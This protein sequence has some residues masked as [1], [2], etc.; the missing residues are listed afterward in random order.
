MATLERR[1]QVLFDPA[2]YAALEREAAEQRQSV[3]AVIREAVDNRLKTRRFSKQEALSRLF[4]RAD[5]LGARGPI[6]RGPIDWE[7]E[8]ESFERDYLRDLP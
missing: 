1:V 3:A 2:Q 4:A 7:E 6:A 5:E 8:K